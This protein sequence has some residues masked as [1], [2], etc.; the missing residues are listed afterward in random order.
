MLIIRSSFINRPL[1]TSS[2]QLCLASLSGEPDDSLVFEEN[3]RDTLPKSIFLLDHTRSLRVMAMAR[4]HG[5]HTVATDQ[6]A[7]EST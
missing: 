6:Q 3:Y 4:L 7:V 1:S 5:R 2:L